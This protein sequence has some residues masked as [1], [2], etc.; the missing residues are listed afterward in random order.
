LK[1]KDHPRALWTPTM[2]PFLLVKSDWYTVTS[3]HNTLMHIISIYGCSS[4]GRLLSCPH[5]L[6]WMGMSADIWAARHQ[7]LIKE[8]GNARIIQVWYLKKNYPPS[9]SLPV[10]VC[11]CVCL[12][13]CLCTTCKLEPIDIGRG[14]YVGT[15]NQT[16]VFCK[17]RKCS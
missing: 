10:C 3:T 2:L 5:L 4:E 8:N 9:L 16:L 14:Y 12:S 1:A 17:S 7:L 6:T 15:E 13:V 11:V